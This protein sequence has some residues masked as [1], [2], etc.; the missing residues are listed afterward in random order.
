MLRHAA[1]AIALVLAAGCTKDLPTGSGFG[2]YQTVRPLPQVADTLRG[3]VQAPA[4]SSAADI[5]LITDGGLAV[6]LV[7]PM[8]AAAVQT[9]GLE[10]WV[11][12]QFT[13]AGEL[14]VEAYDV[15]VAPSGCTI[16]RMIIPVL[17]CGAQVS[18]LHPRGAATFSRR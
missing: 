6:K 17:P 11:A 16:D 8:A 18:G 7:G 13:S 12:G 9:A 15:Q 1:A 10:I 3:V 2:D 5:I 14:M 4:D